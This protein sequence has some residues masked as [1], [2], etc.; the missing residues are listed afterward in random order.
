MVKAV[1]FDLD[2]T[3]LNRDASVNL[4]IENQYKRLAHRLSHIPKE[5]YIQRFIELDQR[6]YVWKDRVYQQLIKEFDLKSISCGEL[7]Q[8]YLYSFKDH[9]VPFPNLIEMLNGLKQSHF[10][11]GVITNG[12]GQFQMDN[13]IALT[14]DAYMDTILISEREGVKKPDP[15]IFQRALARLDVAPED[16]VFIGDH[17]EKD[18]EA[19]KGAGMKTI[20]KRD[21]YW[22]GAEADYIIEDLGEIYGRIQ[23]FHSY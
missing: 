7:L 16:S 6:G 21:Q 4:F 1:I 15:E 23:Q 14:I 5:K 19:A 2:G 18:V 20:W 8:D 9:C 12:K 11:L 22:Y 17:P 3:L 10:L 13:M